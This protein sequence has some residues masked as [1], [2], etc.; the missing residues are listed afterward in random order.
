D[1]VDVSIPRRDSK[2]GPGHRGIAVQG[3]AFLSVAEASRRRDLTINAPLFDPREGAV[4]DPWGGRA[5]LEARRLR[6]VDAATF[7]ED[8][9][10]ALRAVQ[11][12]ARFELSVDPD[13]A[14]LCAGMPLHALPAERG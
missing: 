13:T 1:A 5:D 12:A 6:A 9:L 8:P 4:V 14:A 10:R 2:V 7:G 3:D 11:F